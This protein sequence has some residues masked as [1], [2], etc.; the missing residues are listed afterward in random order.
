MAAQRS[1]ATA[2]SEEPASLR[3]AIPKSFKYSKL[4]RKL[5]RQVSSQFQHWRQHVCM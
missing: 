5:L 1:A 3:A 2:D 4:V